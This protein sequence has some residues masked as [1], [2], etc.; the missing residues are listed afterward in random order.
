[1][2]RT[3]EEIANERIMI[4]DGAM[5]PMIQHYGLSENDYRVERFADMPGQM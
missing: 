3:F 1:M 2:S 5:G 4:L